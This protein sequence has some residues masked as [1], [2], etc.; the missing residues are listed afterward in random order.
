[1]FVLFRFQSFIIQNGII[2]LSCVFVRQGVAPFCGFVGSNKNTWTN[3]SC[4]FDLQ[5]FSGG[6]VPDLYLA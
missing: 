6:R 1:M 4:E 5:V 2:S 3:F